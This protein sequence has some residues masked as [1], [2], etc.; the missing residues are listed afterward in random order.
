MNP[1][2]PLAWEILLHACAYS[3]MPIQYQ[4]DLDYLAVGAALLEDSADARMAYAVILSKTPHKAKGKKSMKKLL[5]QENLSEEQREQAEW[6]ISA[7]F[8]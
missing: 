4:E 2:H 5:R 1:R 6:I 7:V 3:K 8:R